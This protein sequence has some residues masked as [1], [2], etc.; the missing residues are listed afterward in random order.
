[1]KQ[2]FTYFRTLLTLIAF[3]AVNVLYAQSRKITGTVI[4]GDD[5]TPLPGVTVAL[6]GTSIGTQSDANG[7]FSINAASGDVL[8][9]RFIGYS[10]TEVKVGAQQIINVSLATDNKSLK[11]VL[12]VGYGTQSRATVTS[13]V[14]KLDQQVLATQPRA[15]IASALQ[16]TISGLQVVTTSG[17]P[18]ATPIITLRGGASINSPQ[19][20]LI[21]VDGVV[22]AYNDI[23]EEDIASIDVLKDAAATAIYGSR[24]SNG[25]ILITLKKG[26]E[27]TSEINYKYTTAFNQQRQGYQFLDAEQYIYYGRLGSLNSGRSLSAINSSRGYGLLTDPADLASFDI[28]EATPANMGLLKQGWQLMNDP[29]DPGTQ[30]IFKDNEKEIQNMVFRNT[31]TVDQYISASGGTDKG[32]YYA[33]LD[34][35]DEPGVVIGGDYKR[36][37]GDF[38]GTF[39][40]KPNVE[41]T[42]GITFSDN[43][44][45][46]PAASDINTFYRTLS[47]WPTFNPWLDAADTQ[48]NPGNGGSDGNPLYVIQHENNSDNV[49]RIVA[50]AALNWKIIPGLSFKLSG[51]GYYFD[52]LTQGFTDATQSYAQLFANPQTFTTTR[53]A[54]AADSKSLTQTYDADFNYTKSFGKHNFSLLAGGEYYDLINFADEVY[55]TNAPTDNIP[56]VN[57]STLFA[58][59]NNTSTRSEFRI[60]STLARLNYDY[61]QKYLFTA[62]LREDGVSALAPQQRIGYFPGMSAGWNLAK[63]DF[64]QNSGIS[65][66]ISTIKPRIS[67]GENGNV[68]GL[69]N[70]PYLYQGTYNATTGYPQYNGNGAITATQLPDPNLRWETST[71]KDA[72]I[73]MGFFHDRISLIVDYYDK[74]NSN[75]LTNLTL[76]T[77]IGFN[78]ILTNDGTYQNKGL[79]FAL[80]ANIINSPNGFRLDFGATA[81][82]D[83][84]KVL[85]LPDNGQPNNEVGTIQVYDPK[86]G[87]LINVEG[88]QQGQ[89]LGQVYG[90]K[91]IG[92]FQN[93]AQIEA[94]AGNRNDE[95]GKVTGPNLP[96][97][98][99]GHIVPGDVNWEDVNH[100]GI[101]DSRDQVY[102]GNIFPDWTGGYN[103]NASYK[104][105][106]LYTRFDFSLGNVIYN[107]FVARS[108]GQYQGTFN[109]ISEMTNSWSPTN[110]NTMIPRVTYADEVVGS[111]ANYTRAN[112]AAANLDG[113]NSEFYESGNY[114]ACREVTLSYAFPKALL[115]KTRV[116]KSAKIFV[117]GDN[118]FYVKSFSGPDPEAPVSTSTP[119]EIGGV[120]QGSYPTPRTYVLGVSVSL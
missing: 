54:Y 70:T 13:S 92:I 39:K 26:K 73:D 103:I 37:S 38:N 23:A 1:M 62:V 91:E 27:G 41:V 25:V 90:Y 81:S 20:P 87:G 107:D 61:D 29:A 116:F 84:N 31:Q 106:S 5:H 45:T 100:D 83:K 28:Q 114:M 118:L 96:A 99:G 30:I 48:P 82:Y 21:I 19:P 44:N 17:E 56:T 75:L 76:P 78:S 12:V 69:Q 35:Y 16:G 49:A 58:A 104:G 88:E 64:F 79:E 71:T 72:G 95:I 36:Y 18:G 89:A 6:K 7:S 120:Y 22:R 34:Y 111:G 40:V 98:A 85:K 9:F 50:N 66:I 14:A 65:K 46:G 42:S 77:Y 3:L 57:A 53:P 2:N 60:I 47:L 43:E 8:V 102:L 24:A 112:N 110:T 11:E 94:V 86:T 97:G 67:Y 101:I 105:F 10:P 119:N 63:E 55:G 115:A 33:S 51:S 74:I 108:L 52:E 117:S 68:S 109:M 4:S 113:E 80:H 32:T 59:G 93:E 15:S